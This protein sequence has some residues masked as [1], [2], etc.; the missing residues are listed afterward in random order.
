MAQETSDV[1][2]GSRALSRTTAT[3][4]VTR[5]RARGWD[6][7]FS[8]GHAGGLTCSQVVEYK[9]FHKMFCYTIRLI[10]L[11]FH[12]KAML[13]ICHV[14][15]DVSVNVFVEK[16]YSVSVLLCFFLVLCCVCE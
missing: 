3:F 14:N 6:S 4:L 8:S 15:Y 9:S 11:C 16:Q 10:R 2:K 12:R 1:T 13:C 5:A 7:Q